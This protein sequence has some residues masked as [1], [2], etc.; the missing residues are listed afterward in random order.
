[1]ERKRGKGMPADGCMKGCRKARN[2]IG[3]SRGERGV[4]SVLGYTLILGVVILVLTLVFAHTYSMVSQAKNK[5]RYESM[6]QGFEKIQN[7]VNYVA[8]SG[9]PQRYIRILLNEGSMSVTKGCWLNIS[10]YNSTSPS[11][12]YTMSTYSGAIVYSYSGYSIAFENGGVW[13]NSHGYPT[14]VSPPRIFI[15][16]K[17]INNQTIFFMALTILKGNGSVGGNGF[18]DVR[19]M[20]NSS[21][22]RV[23]G[24]GFVRINITS[25]YARAWYN[26]FNSLKNSGNTAAIQATIKGKNVSATIYFSEMVLTTYYLNVS[27]T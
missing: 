15:Y 19:V 17:I 21:R 12:A 6:A 5:V 16:K 20:F 23:F 4:S 1:M 22:V 7:M 27:V 26:Y 3:K 8:Y 18:A 11:P 9:T 13:L 2:R 25:D 10:V 14:V 24:P